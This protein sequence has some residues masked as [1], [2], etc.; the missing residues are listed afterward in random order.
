MCTKIESSKDKIGLF[1]EYI[2][3][4][5]TNPA[6]MTLGK[7]MLSAGNV[8]KHRRHNSTI[9]NDKWMKRAGGR[10]YRANNMS[11][12]KAGGYNWGRTILINTHS[13]LA[14]RL[15]VTRTTPWNLFSSPRRFS[16]S[17][18][19]CASHRYHSASQLHLMVGNLLSSE[20]RFIPQNEK[21]KMY[22]GSLSRK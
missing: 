21:K 13:S 16:L 12:E 1:W 14:E 2:N 10:S 17:R 19:Q 5:T 6:K 7:T 4:Y 15:R 22:L 11:Q 9:M 8:M 3:F 20:I 18:F